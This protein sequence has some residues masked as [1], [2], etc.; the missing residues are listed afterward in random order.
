M[1]PLARFLTGSASRGYLSVIETPESLR[2]E[3][4]GMGYGSSDYNMGQADAAMSDA[5]DSISASRRDQR[6]M[7]KANAL[8]DQKQF[9]A[10]SLAGLAAKRTR[11]VEAWDNIVWELVKRIKDFDPETRYRILGVCK[12]QDA[13]P[14]ETLRELRKVQEAWYTKLQENAPKD[15]TD[16]DIPVIRADYQ[17][18]A[19]QKYPC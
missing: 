2:A 17:K 10:N 11:G 4:V 16:T 9:V 12:G 6:N 3:E 14:E 19:E 8:L 13:T 7:D 15:K 5:I 18:Q 1:E